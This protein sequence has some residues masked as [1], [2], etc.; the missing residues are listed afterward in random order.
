[1][2]ICVVVHDVYSRRTKRD[3]SGR[4]G[5]LSEEW[6]RGHDQ[7]L[8]C[9]FPGGPLKADVHENG[10]GHGGILLVI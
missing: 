1:M 5:A 6:T 3:G 2:L 10:S 8:P 7:M 9:G 4:P